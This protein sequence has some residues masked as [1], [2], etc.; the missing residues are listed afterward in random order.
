[1]HST[2]SVEIALRR[3]G[4]YELTANNCQDFER[5]LLDEFALERQGRANAFHADDRRLHNGAVDYNT[6]GLRAAYERGYDN[7][8]RAFRDPYPDNGKPGDGA[9]DFPRLTDGSTTPSRRSCSS[10]AK[11]VRN[12]H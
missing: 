3:H 6:A 8:A 4:K 5:V 9:N 2:T 7:Q 10:R 11:W 12:I 1:M